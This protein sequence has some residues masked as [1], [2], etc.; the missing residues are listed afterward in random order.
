MHADHEIHEF[1]RVA[2]RSIQDILDGLDRYVVAIETDV[3]EPARKERVEAV[4]LLE[5]KGNVWTGPLDASRA[6]VFVN[7][8][9]SVDDDV[10]DIAST[11]ASFKTLVAKLKAGH[12]A[13]AKDQPEK[14]STSDVVAA[15]ADIISA[16]T[17][18]GTAISVKSS[19]N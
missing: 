7:Y 8:A 12:S 15:V 4:E 17:Q 10:L 5:T 14:S 18:V 9:K 2:D 1:A 3:V 6:I 11:F 13:L 19:S 16:L